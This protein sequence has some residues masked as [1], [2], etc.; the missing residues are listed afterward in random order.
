LTTKT[1]TN[2]CWKMVYINNKITSM[3]LPKTLVKNDVKIMILKF[4]WS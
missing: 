3:I 4:W 2:F 1:M